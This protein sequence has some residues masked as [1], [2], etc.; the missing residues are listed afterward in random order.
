MVCFHFLCSVLQDAYKLQHSAY[1]WRN[2]SCISIWFRS[3][4][5]LTY[6][7]HPADVIYHRALFLF[8]KK[9]AAQEGHHYDSDSHPCSGGMTVASESECEKS[10]YICIFQFEESFCLFSKARHY[11]QRSCSIFLKICLGKDEQGITGYGNHF[12]KLAGVSWGKMSSCFTRAIG[13]LLI[14]RVWGA[15]RLAEE[16]GW[17]QMGDFSVGWL[18]G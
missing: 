13:K 9:I 16:R 3:N 18:W 8:Q 17:E 6:E 2:K 5:C 7:T 14:C 1:F 10:E 11:S 15:T 4:V 12:P